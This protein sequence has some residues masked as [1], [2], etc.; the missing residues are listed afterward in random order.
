MAAKK[1]TKKTTRKTREPK[2]AEQAAEET[3]EENGSQNGAPVVLPPAEGTIGEADYGEVMSNNFMIYAKSVLVDRALPSIDGL[4]PVQRRILLGMND[5][6]LRPNARYLKSAK[7]VGDVM[8]TYHPHGD[9]AIYGALVNMAQD[10]TSRVPLVDGHGNF[11]SLDGDAAAAMRYTECRMTQAAVDLIEDLHPKVLPNH[12]GMNFDESKPEPHVLPARWPNILINGNTGIAVGMATTILPHNPAEVIDLCTWR[13]KNPKASVEKLAERLS[14][15]DFP[16]G[17]TVLDDEGLRQSY[18]NGKGKVTA[19]AKAHI[20]PIEGN[21]EK[22]VITEI[23]WGVN[24]GD[25]LAK[26]A[27]QH[28][29]GK[30]PEITELNDYSKGDH[31]I[32]VE[33]VLKWGANSRAVLQRLLKHTALRKVYGVEMN[34]LVEGVPKTVNL[35]EMIDYFLDF[36]REVV[37][38]R[39]K[40]RIEEIEERL[41]RL[42]AYMKVVNATDKVVATIRKAKDRAAAK[43]P[44]KRLLKIDD[45]Q[46]QWIVEMQLG[47]L[48]QLD[49]FKLK[50]EVKTLNAELKELKKFIR[51]KDL[52]TEAMIEEFGQIKDAFKKAGLVDRH[53]TLAAPSEG[54]EVTTMSVPAEDCI[55]LISRSGRAIAGQGTLKRGA[56]LNLSADDRLAVVEEARTDQERLI[57]TASGRAYRLRLAELPLESRRSK[58]A[59]LSKIIGVEQGD[60]IVGAHDFTAGE[61]GA[62]DGAVLLVSRDGVV[63][64]SAWSEFSSAHASGIVAGK[65]GAGDEIVSVLDCPDDADI[66]LVGSHGKA[67][68]FAAS[69]ARLMGRNAAGVRGIRLPEGARIVS[70]VVIRPDEEKGGQLL[71]ATTTGFAKRIPYSELSKQGRGGGGVALMKVG[72]KY[73]EPK[74]AAPARDGQTL[75]VEVGGGRFKSYPVSRVAKTRKRAIVPKRWPSGELAVGVVLADD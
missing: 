53:T 30:F 45:Q 56:S 42:D 1:N 52:V 48:T 66:V 69:E 24:K 20:E 12:Y 39:A 31:E 65:V 15:P 36:R 5:R 70:A 25:L 50:E 22:I 60:P 74:F 17:G 43:P 3:A 57:F 75:Y 13:L 64:R 33:A 46:A 18:V 21:R 51:S 44:L 27:K 49:R 7:V 35:A 72:G 61:D 40:K 2:Q 14:G 55:L 68:R 37:I 11:G 63:K 8:G 62:K 4:K 10:F 38:N 54:E 6:N 58:G 67:I 16:T 71:L 73:G 29:D 26:I 23:P 28:S 59:E 34:I 47:Q 32:R 19:L 41:H 9:A